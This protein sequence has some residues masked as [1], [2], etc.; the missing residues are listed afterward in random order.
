MLRNMKNHTESVSGIMDEKYS[1][2]NCQLLDA[3]FDTMAS[4]RKM[5][6]ALES[7]IKIKEM[8]VEEL[9]RYQE[10]FRQEY[11]QVCQEKEALF[12]D[13]HALTN[14]VECLD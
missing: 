14:K 4:L 6:Q 2:M 7:R 5:T 13:N 9:L 12:H 1:M 11:L 3:N 10:E 8:E